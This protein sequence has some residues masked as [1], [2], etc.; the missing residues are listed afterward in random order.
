MHAHEPVPNERWGPRRGR[1]TGARGLPSAGPAAGRQHPAATPVPA[2]G[3]PARL[4]P[5]AMRLVIGLL[6]A[7]AL[8]AFVALGAL[9]ARATAAGRGRPAAAPAV[10]HIPSMSTPSVGVPLVTLSW[11]SEP[12]SVGLAR[13]LEGLARGPEALAVAPDGRIAVLDSVNRRVVTLD[14]SGAFVAALPLALSDPRFIAVDDTTIYVLDADED[15]SLVSLDW[16]GQVV[17][18]DAL[19][20]TDTV[21][22]GIFAREGQAYV[23][24]A[25]ERV[26]AV[27]TEGARGF[28]ATEPG[29]PMGPHGRGFAVARQARGDNPRVSLVND[30]GRP[31]D[32]PGELE[33]LDDSPVDHLVSLDADADGAVILGARLEQ[34][35]SAGPDAPALV[36]VRTTGS[37]T[38]ATLALDDTG[39]IAETGQPYVVAPD[40]RVYQPRAT[41]QGYS[42]VV[43]TFAEGVSR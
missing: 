20:A 16:Q 41:E 22:T 40:G 14:P 29:R 28:A 21:V 13:P 5:A 36:I 31:T 6:I 11:G 1:A 7:A 18:Q 12:G 8:V 3:R 33:F 32:L 39:N 17:A 34:S 27:K 4:R 25:H 15:R 9:T 42:I 19:E 43:H 10:I 24:W 23:E 2:T 38:P 26:A 37:G 30:P 35:S